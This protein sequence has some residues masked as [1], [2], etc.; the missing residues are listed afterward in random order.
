MDSVPMRTVYRNKLLLIIT[1]PNLFRF[2]GRDLYSR[3]WIPFG[4]GPAQS[5]ASRTVFPP[6]NLVSLFL[7]LFLIRLDTLW[8]T[9]YKICDEICVNIYR[10]SWG[11]NALI[12]LT[13]LKAN[14]R[15]LHRLQQRQPR[16]RRSPQPRPRRRK[17]VLKKR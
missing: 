6:G 9:E 4:I 7:L 16:Q 12:C 15:R 3:R 1:D 13:R 11:T 10:C 14:P 17:L 2:Y 8:R 5:F